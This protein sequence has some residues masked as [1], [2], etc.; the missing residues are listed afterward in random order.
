[1]FCLDLE[2]WGENTIM[3]LLL[4]ELNKCITPVLKLLQFWI[5]SYIFVKYVWYIKQKIK[6]SSSERSRVQRLLQALNG[7]SLCPQRRW[8]PFFLFYSTHLL[9]HCC[10][11]HATAAAV[12]TSFCTLVKC[13]A[14]LQ[15]PA[16]QIHLSSHAFAHCRQ[17]ST[18]V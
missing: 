18:T 15:T 10:S 2:T 4:A 5:F 8:K 12:Y 9:W 1:M 13:I 17:T 6:C 16:W 11:T 3:L 7:A 14:T